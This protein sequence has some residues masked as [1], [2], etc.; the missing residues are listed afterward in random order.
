MGL[1]GLYG[2]F[3]GFL[4]VLKSLK[5]SH[6]ASSDCQEEKA[7]E[8]R[9]RRRQQHSEPDKAREGLSPAATATNCSPPAA[10]GGEGLETP[11]DSSPVKKKGGRADSC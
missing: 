11:R 3:V 1:L 9:Q 10:M 4:E 5:G 6:V 7:N 8:N 2:V